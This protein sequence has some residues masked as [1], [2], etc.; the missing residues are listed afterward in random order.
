M[1]PKNKSSISLWEEF[2]LTY[3][4]LYKQQLFASNY[5]TPSFLS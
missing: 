1:V 5:S 3:A 4:E 2:A